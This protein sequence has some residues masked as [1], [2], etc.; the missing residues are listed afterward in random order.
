MPTEDQSPI[1]KFLLVAEIAVAIYLVMLALLKKSFL[2]H[3]IHAQMEWTDAQ[4]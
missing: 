4:H 2:Q 3:Y 1:T